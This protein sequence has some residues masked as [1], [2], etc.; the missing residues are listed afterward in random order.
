M[1]RLFLSIL[2][3]LY[4]NSSKYQDEKSIMFIGFTHLNQKGL[5]RLSYT[6]Q[7][8][9]LIDEESV[10]NSIFIGE[11]N[12]ASR[13]CLHNS[14]CE[15]LFGINSSLTYRCHCRAGYTGR[16]CEVGTALFSLVVL[17]SRYFLSIQL[18]IVTSCERTPCIH[19]QC[20]KIDLYTEICICEENWIGVDCSEAVSSKTFKVEFNFYIRKLHSRSACDDHPYAYCN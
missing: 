14:T 1:I 19:G 3:A 8:S 5:E 2:F 17:L 18:A 12:C 7:R 15:S 16:N 10:H 6:Y 20:I 11:T 13:P 9:F 4:A